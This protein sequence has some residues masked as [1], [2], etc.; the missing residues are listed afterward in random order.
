MKQYVIMYEH[1]RVRACGA[2]PHYRLPFGHIH[3]PLSPIPTALAAWPE[4]SCGRFCNRRLC[5]DTFL[6]SSPDGVTA[7]LLTILIL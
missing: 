7:V 3:P 1:H 5:F 2:A 6:L 4:P